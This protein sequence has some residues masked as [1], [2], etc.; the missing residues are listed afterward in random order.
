MGN[1]LLE[2]HLYAVEG[3]VQAAINFHKELKYNLSFTALGGIL[4]KFEHLKTSINDNQSQLEDELVRI[5]ELFRT[6]EIQCL[7]LS[8]Q[9][10]E[11]ASEIKA[12]REEVESL[13]KSAEVNKQ[14]LKDFHELKK[15]DP[16]AL[17][18][19]VSKLDGQMTKLKERSNIRY[20]K[21]QNQFSDKCSETKQLT[22]RIKQLTTRKSEKAIEGHTG[23]LQYFPIVIESPL[24]FQYL[25][26]SCKLG[27]LALDWHIEIM[28]S[29][30]VSVHCGVTEWLTGIIPYS[31]EMQK[32]WTHEV[33]DFIHSIALDRLATSHPNNIEMVKQAKAVPL[34]EVPEFTEREQKLF[35]DLGFQSLFD[36]VSLNFTSFY[37]RASQCGFSEDDAANCYDTINRY[38]LV[39]RKLYKNL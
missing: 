9:N 36:V 17:K 38:G 5:E 35:D 21:L 12:L 28:S 23:T 27:S 7:S 32:D 39:Y 2:E 4:E 24:E 10:S 18:R 11:S 26:D 34:S 14:H 3:S 15:L 31:A 33:Q 30:G 13:R 19:Q 20:N 8:I 16:M 25:D 22:D 6:Q 37:K 1:K 29:E